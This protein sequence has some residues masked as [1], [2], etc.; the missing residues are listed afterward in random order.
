[1]PFVPDPQQTPAAP[2][3]RAPVASAAPPQ[4]A[5]PTGSRFVPDAPAQQAPPS[6]GAFKTAGRFLANMGES[7]LQM[8]T[9]VP[10]AVIGAVGYAGSAVGQAAG[11]NTNPDQ[12]QAD[13]ANRFTYQPRVASATPNADAAI[14]RFVTPIAQGVS[15][16]YGN[17]TQS[18]QDAYGQTAGDA[19]RAAPGAFKAASAL[20]PAAAGTRTAVGAA[21][22][23]AMNATAPVTTAQAVRNVVAPAAAPK[24][25]PPGAK[26]APATTAEEVVARQA[27][28]SAQNMGAA[29]SAVNVANASPELKAAIVDAARKTGGAVN[30]EA[31][32][33]LTDADEVFRGTGAKLSTGQALQDARLISEEQNMRGAVPEFGRQF[34][35]QAPALANRLRTIRDEAGADVFSANHVEHGDTLMNAYRTVDEARQAQV[36]AAYDA[37]RQAAN[38]K[39]PIGAQTLLDNATR[40][41]HKGLIFD[42]A[43][44]SVMNAL[45]SFAAKPGSMSFENFEA[46]RTNLATIQRTATDGLERRAAGIIR[47]Q[48]EELPLASGAARLKPLADNARRLA[49]ERFAA[50]EA[51]P[52]YKAVVDGTVEPDDF[53][54]KFVTGGKR[55]NLSRMAQTIGA[56]EA[57]RQTMGVAALDYLR[58]AARLNPHFEGN[59]AADSFNKA[60]QKLG[61]GVQSMLPAGTIEKLEQLGRVARATT[62]EPR[63]G[64]VNRSNTFTAAAAEGAKSGVEGAVNVAAHGVPVGTWIRKGMEGAST[65]RRAKAAFDP[66]SALSSLEPRR[67]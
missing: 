36:T 1:M 61:P 18:V 4:N 12:V 59:F 24:P 65:K 29:A 15:E 23:G 31:L 21:E 27:A 16:G 55:D 63:G 66:R 67:P 28:Q 39:F 34:E 14:N 9:S 60:L 43:P 51:D 37:L 2:P 50:I 22:R 52:A 30:P 46:L 13:L 6:E 11:M 19:M 32:Q 33:R 53:V 48:M 25:V 45:T 7:G 44:K 56:D 3:A 20:V 49:R 10:A 35:A 47:Q 42:H 64:F 40:E 41:L 57:A 26:L 17:V 62:F 58:D 54:R 5:A 8:V 38:G